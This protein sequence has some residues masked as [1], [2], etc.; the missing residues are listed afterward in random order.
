[1]SKRKTEKEQASSVNT[2]IPSFGRVS[3]PAPTTSAEI[4]ITVWLKQLHP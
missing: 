4:L 3:A 1:M 2:F